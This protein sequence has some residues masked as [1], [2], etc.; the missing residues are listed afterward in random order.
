DAFENCQAAL[1]D[2]TKGRSYGHGTKSGAEVG[3]CLQNTKPLVFQGGGPDTSDQRF[4]TLSCVTD[5]CP[6][7]AGQVAG[8]LSNCAGGINDACMTAFS[9][10]NAAKCN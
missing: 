7:I 1:P 5:A 4:A 6:E 2:G 3:A 10:L 9:T 8:V